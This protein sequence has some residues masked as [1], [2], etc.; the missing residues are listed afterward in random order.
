MRRR[1]PVPTYTAPF[2][3]TT[4][5]AY[6]VADQIGITVVA[7][8]PAGP[9]QPLDVTS[10]V[11]K[12]ISEVMFEANVVTGVLFVVGILLCSWPGAIW[13]LLGSLVGTLTGMSYQAPEVN[14]S[15]GIYGYNAALAAMALGLYRPSIMLPIVGAVLS[16]PFT[17]KLPFIGLPALTA[18]FVISC[19]IIIGLDRLDKRLFKQVP[20]ATG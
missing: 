2:I 12:G 20:N 13:A 4:W 5:V 15:L 10:A 1:L 7:S 16:V 19:W 9:E 17:E 11:V 18:P 14:L 8:A 6:Y 3:V